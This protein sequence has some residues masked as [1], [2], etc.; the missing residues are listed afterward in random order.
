MLK[1]YEM[2]KKQKS[3]KNYDGPS[4]VSSL[5]FFSNVHSQWPVK[6]CRIPL[7]CMKLDPRR[8]MEWK[9]FNNKKKTKKKFTTSVVVNRTASNIHNIN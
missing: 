6:E 7:A 8:P 5:I 2:K 9:I 1:T 3:R 4:H